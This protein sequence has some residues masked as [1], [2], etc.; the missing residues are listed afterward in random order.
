ML[1]RNLIRFFVLIIMSMFL[2]SCPHIDLPGDIKGI[3][4]DAETSEPIY[5]VQIKLDTPDDTTRTGT[6]GSYQL[7][8]VDP[9]SHEIQASKF[10]YD[11]ETENVKVISERQV[12]KN[13]SLTKIATITVSTTSL[14]FGIDSTTLKFKLSKSGTGILTYVISTSQSWL[15]TPPDRKTGS[16]IEET[17][18]VTV[19]ISI[20]KTVVP[21]GKCKETITVSD[22]EGNQEVKIG[23]YVNGLW[24]K[25][26]SDSVYRYVV[27][28]GTQVWMGEN[29][30]VGTRIDI[31]K[32]QTDNKIV[33]KYC[34]NDIDYNCETYGG[35]YLWDEAMQYNP[36][37]DTG[38]ITGTT[39]GICPAGWHIPTFIEWR[40][41]QEYLGGILEA[42]GKLK[43]TGTVH[44]ASP[45]AGA[46][47]ES[48]FSGLPAG[49][50]GF[51]G[52]DPGFFGMGTDCFWWTTNI[53][54]HTVDW[55]WT[56]GLFYD[57]ANFEYRPGMVGMG[58]SVRCIR[59]P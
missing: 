21:K 57:K 46:T 50:R 54:S 40:T 17:D 43:E 47:N 44:W 6:D 24:F 9:G 11:P 3:V 12:E 29:E 35:L 41:L 27:P 42:G 5:Q 28:I 15:T 7:N 19:V 23:V 26:G 33:E 10:G 36:A 1:T 8:N 2:Y 53:E 34:Y 4:T 20:N 14:D 30:N 39:Q 59:N 16:I 48:G 18:T 45:N 25:S 13:F 51:S 55:H 49:C 32:N 56:L 37:E 58:M 52:E 38:K 22:L 31:G